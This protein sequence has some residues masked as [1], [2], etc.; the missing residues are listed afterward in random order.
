MDGAVTKKGEI[1]WRGQEIYERDIR[2]EV[3]SD[4]DGEFVVGDVTDGS[5][6]VDPSN[7]AASEHVLAKNPNAVVLY[8]ACRAS[9]SLPDR[10]LLSSSGG[11]ARRRSLVGRA[12][13]D[14]WG[15]RSRRRALAAAFL[16]R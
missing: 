5:H 1:A 12:R 16:R 6:E 15:L 8:S 4:H 2:Q 14:P 9:V 3:E 13:R 10:R 11:P 7:V